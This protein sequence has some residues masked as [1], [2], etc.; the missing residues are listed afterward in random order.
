MKVGNRP[1]RL[2]LW[3]VYAF[4]CC[5]SC[6]REANSPLKELEGLR[7]GLHKGVTHLPRTHLEWSSLHRR[8]GPQ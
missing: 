5:R 1:P 8:S 7:M 6:G 2:T 3:D 4:D